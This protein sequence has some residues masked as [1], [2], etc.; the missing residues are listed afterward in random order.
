MVFGEHADTK[1]AAQVEDLFV[2]NSF[3][4]SVQDPV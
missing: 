1:I 4:G 3:C 2:V